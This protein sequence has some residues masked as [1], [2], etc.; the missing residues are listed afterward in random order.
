MWLDLVDIFNF[1][2]DKMWLLNLILTSDANLHLF[3]FK[4]NCTYLYPNVR[5]QHAQHLN[6]NIWT[7]KFELLRVFGSYICVVFTKCVF[8]CYQNMYM[9]FQMYFSSSAFTLYL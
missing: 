5:S 3:I 1:I 2:W 4:W 6:E 9:H 8:K 7:K